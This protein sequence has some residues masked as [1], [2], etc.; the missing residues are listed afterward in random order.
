MFLICE[1][2]LLLTFNFTT[3]CIFI[4]CTDHYYFT[5][6]PLFM[7]PSEDVHEDLLLSET[8]VEPE[9][10]SE[11]GASQMDVFSNKNVE[12]ALGVCGR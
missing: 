11:L 10:N 5:L 6:L 1:I 9:V 7:S 12:D 4:G 2:F 3:H 8:D